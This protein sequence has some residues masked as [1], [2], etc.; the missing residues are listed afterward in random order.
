M[1]LPT[2][3]ATTVSA[4]GSLAGLAATAALAYAIKLMQTHVSAKHLDE[5]YSIVTTAVKAAEQMGA[6]KLIGSAKF[7]LAEQRVISELARVGIVLT[8]Q[9]VQTRI[10]AAV[11]DLKAA[12]VAVVTATPPV[13]PTEAQT[14]AAAAAALRA[15]ADQIDAAPAPAVI[16][17]MI[18]ATD[19]IDAMTATVTS[20]T[21]AGGN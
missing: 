2:I 16:V 20:A 7:Q 15:V 10:E 12:G 6:G 8:P 19:A 5:A 21:V 3:D 13:A 11:T 18:P 14:H 9:Q 4:F 1:T 17:N